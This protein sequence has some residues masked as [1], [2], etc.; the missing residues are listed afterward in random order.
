M[1]I[2][3]KVN[4]D[5]QQLKFLCEAGSYFLSK[6]RMS[7]ACDIFHGVIA[8]APEKAIGYTL[9]G[10]ALMNWEKF[11]ESIHA[12][13]KALELEPDNNFARVYYAQA[14]LFKKQRDK[15]VAEL[16]KVLEKDPN[17]PDGALAKHLMKGVEQGIFS[18]L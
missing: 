11:D 10:D 18:R 1:S 15:A 13:Q 5:V 14:L 6:A 16:R 4:P 12:H 2:Q 17:G 9:L 8:L 7:E 3:Q